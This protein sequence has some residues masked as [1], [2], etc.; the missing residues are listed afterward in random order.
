MNRRLF[1]PLVLAALAP[2]SAGCQGA[3][4]A[5]SEDEL[6]ASSRS[7]VTVTKDTRK[8]V[9]PLCGGY[10][11][12]DV[13]RKTAATYVSDLDF[14]PAGL[15]AGALEDARSAP[16]E[17]LVLRG[18]LGP[19]EASFGTRAFLVSEVY[20]GM[21]GVT[22]VAGEA[23]FQAKPRS[24]QISC[25]AAPCP[26]EVATKLNS[27]D[28]TNFDGYEVA[29]AQKPFVDAAWLVERVEHHGAVVAARWS[30]GQTYPAGVEK[31]LDA[32]QVYVRLPAD[33][34]PCPAFKLAACPAGQSWTYTRTVDLCLTPDK[35]ADDAGCPS[36]QPAQCAEG[37]DLASWRT[38]T[39]SCRAF[40]CDPSF[41]VVTQ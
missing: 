21:P 2:L 30:D 3:E 40:A 32:S 19:K 37:Y 41:V 18:K 25:F 16:P 27:T 12:E 31:L 9:A 33:P 15:G 28:K 22:P 36:L 6:S 5:D 29:R 1:A 34:G 10:W 38:D 24:P 20:R 8:C 11:V 7:Y 26:N 13:N 23:F 17:E 35:C 14:S 39:A 4:T